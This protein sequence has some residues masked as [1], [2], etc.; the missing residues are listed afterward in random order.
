MKDGEEYPTRSPETALQLID[1][2][3][4]CPEAAAALEVICAYVLSSGTGDEMGFSV[5][6]DEQNPQLGTV[7]IAQ[8]VIARVGDIFTWWQVIWRMMTWGDAFGLLDVDTKAMMVT[9]LRLLPSWQCFVVPDEVTGELSHYEQRMGRGEVAQIPTL[10]MIQWSYNRRYLY[11]RSLYHECLDDWQRMQNASEDVSAGSRE[12]VINPNLH[13]MPPGSDD[14]Y[15][16]AYKDDHEARKKQGLVTDIYLL[17]GAGCA[18][19][20]G[21]VGFVPD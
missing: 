3:N 13:F 5:Q 17:P 18:E 11:G 1:L 12:A 2:V 20:A 21:V 8:N 9:G 10:N 16:R 15:K 7:A 19:A 6:V 4:N 14:G